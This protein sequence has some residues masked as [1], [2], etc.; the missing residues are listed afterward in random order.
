MGVSVEFEFIEFEM[1]QL[2]EIVGNCMGRAERNEL[3]GKLVLRF[4]MGALLHKCKP[5]LSCKMQKNKENKKEENELKLTFSFVESIHHIHCCV[6][7]F[8]F[9]RN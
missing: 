7:N 4:F 2:I 6:R 9:V 8:E 1:V 5:T 3:N